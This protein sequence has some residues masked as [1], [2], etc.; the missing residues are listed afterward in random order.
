MGLHAKLVSSLRSCRARTGTAGSRFKCSLIDCLLGL[1]WKTLGHK[2][3]FA[4]TRTSHFRYFHSI[5]WMFYLASEATF[6][7][8]GIFGDLSIW[9][10]SIRM[11]EAQHMSRL[12]D[13]KWISA[14][15]F[16]TSSSLSSPPWVCHW[17]LVIVLNQHIS[18]AFLMIPWVF[19]GPSRAVLFTWNRD[20]WGKR[21]KLG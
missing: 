7:R 1:S 4:A 12:P 2:E 20:R 16:R 17:M 9:G 19:P 5:I 10:C 3:L 15:I 21:K 8:D 18:A 14:E 11:I 6:C 13:K